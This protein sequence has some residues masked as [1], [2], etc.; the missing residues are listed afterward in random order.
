MVAMN[1]P[2]P[3][4]YWVEPGR[5]L[6]GTYPGA[7]RLDEAG[8]R[9]NALLDAGI[10]VIINLMEEYETGWMGYECEPYEEAIRLLAEGRGLSV[11]CRRI[12]IEDMEVPTQ[13]VME[14]VLDAVDQAM[15]Q[16][17]PVYVHCWGGRGRTGTVVGCWL[18]RHGRAAG[19][20]ALDL[21]RKLRTGSQ[22]RFQPSPET[23]KQREMVRVWK[24]GG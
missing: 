6:A 22:T 4:S 24:T 20:E 1:V 12:P 18:A 9:L 21:I 8:R 23:E 19:D 14:S 7:Q 15:E 16:E 3:N 13:E 11:A 17:K 5:F 2:F 10:R